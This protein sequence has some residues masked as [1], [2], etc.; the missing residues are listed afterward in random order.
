MPVM[1]REEFEHKLDG[2]MKRWNWGDRTDLILAL[3]SPDVRDFIYEHLVEPVRRC[4]DSEHGS[5]AICEWC[6]EHYTPVRKNQRFHSKKCKNA[7]WSSERR[8]KEREER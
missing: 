7:W 4:M 3:S 5:D 2:F 1:T 6:G 8:R